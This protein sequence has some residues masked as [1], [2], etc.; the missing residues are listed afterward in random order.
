MAKIF[1]SKKF[2]LTITLG[3]LCEIYWPDFHFTSLIEII[4]IKNRE[5]NTQFGF[6]VQE[7]I[8]SMRDSPGSQIATKCPNSTQIMRLFFDVKKIS[9]LVNANWNLVRQILKFPRQFKKIKIQTKIGQCLEKFENL[10]TNTSTNKI[11]R[12]IFTE[13]LMS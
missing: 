8:P 6:L 10:R 2:S 12:L 3:C 5:S 1:Y 7:L 11:I 13:Y 4:I 9:L